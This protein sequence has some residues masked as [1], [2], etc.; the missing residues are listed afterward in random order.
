MS[1]FKCFEEITPQEEQTTNSSETT[2]PHRV[3]RPQRGTPPNRRLQASLGVYDRRRRNKVTPEQPRN[4]RVHRASRDQ[5]RD[6]RY[7]T[8]P[9][10]LTKSNIVLTNKQIQRTQHGRRANFKK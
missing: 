10:A 8:I 6:G 5:P 7:S 1:V 4:G 9:N 3:N 2:S